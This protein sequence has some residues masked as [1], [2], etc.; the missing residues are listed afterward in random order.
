MSAR[1]VEL[2]EYL[3]SNY[4]YDK[5]W[6]N[7]ALV[8]RNGGEFPHSYTLTLLCASLFRTCPEFIPLISVRVQTSSTAIRV[9]DFAIHRSDAPRERIIAHPPLLVIEVK[10]PED[11]LAMLSEKAGE[12]LRFGIEHVWVID[13]YARVAYR[14]TEGGLELV[15]SGELTIPGTP[16]RVVPQEIFADLDC[17]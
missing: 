16:I 17:V 7:G 9:P 1:L 11:T 12:Y 8:E 14:G 6:V 13:P 15:R 3:H 4:E 2:E 10:A 5:E